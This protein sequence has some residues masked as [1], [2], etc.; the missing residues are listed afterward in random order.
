[1]VTMFYLWWVFHGISKKTSFFTCLIN[2][3]L[4]CPTVQLKVAQQMFCE[5]IPTN[6]RPG[7]L[8]R[9]ILQTIIILSTLLIESRTEMKITDMIFFPLLQKSSLIY[10][11]AALFT[12]VSIEA[13]LLITERIEDKNEKVYCSGPKGNSGVL[14]YISSLNHVVNL[15]G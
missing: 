3:P 8:L 12:L 11:S 4:W 9:N 2:Q 14:L 1:M 10:S 13:K 6:Q 5:Y 15:G 7:I